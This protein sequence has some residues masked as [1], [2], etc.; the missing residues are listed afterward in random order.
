MATDSATTMLRVEGRDARALLH[1][2][3]TNF[4]A[5]LE[6][7][8]ARATLFCD[9]RGRLLHRAVVCA[10][11]DGAL[12][13]VRDDAPGAPL[14]KFVDRHVF[15]ED[16]RVSDLS[17]SWRVD[18]AAPVET[19]SPCAATERDG[20]PV[21]IQLEDAAWL[22]HPASQGAGV[23]PEQ[24]LEHERARVHAG[25]AAHGHEI[26]DEFTPFEV[27]LDR[28]VHLDKGCY[29]GQEALLRMV[30][31]RS[32]RRRLARIEDRDRVPPSPRDILRAGQRVGRLTSVAAASG[33]PGR[34]IGL[35]V[36]KTDVE[37]ADD[38]EI[39]GAAVERP[40]FFPPGRPL[41]WPHEV[42]P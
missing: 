24:R 16:V 5:D 36:L 17:D 42:R 28:E 2:I 33:E 37:A 27:G 1:R 12:W 14:A 29:T 39:D 26:V 34:W 18:R 38:L 4:L 3:S 25:H 40:L 41:G 9:F 35:A 11:S 10:A 13:L 32:I 6:P 8:H 15:R 30:T 23:S 21:A 19:M 20:V 31:Y 22:V 7:G